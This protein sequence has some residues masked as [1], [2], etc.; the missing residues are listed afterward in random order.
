MQTEF[1][2]DSLLISTHRLKRRWVELCTDLLPVENK[3]TI[4]RYSRL[5]SEA[6]PAQGWKIHVSSTVLTA[7]EILSA[8]GPYLRSQGILFKAPTSL[9]VL[10]RLNSGIFYGY[11]QIGKFIT[12]YPESERQFKSLVPALRQLTANWHSGPT[13]PFDIR[14]QKSCIYY[15]YGAFKTRMTVTLEGHSVTS[16]VKPDGS[17]IEDSRHISSEHLG[18]VKDPISKG[19]KVSSKLHDGL[20]NDRYLVFR[21]LAQ[22]GKGG[23]YE[24]LDLKTDP[25]RL[26]ILKEGRSNGETSWD[27]RDGTWRIMNET[28][29]LNLLGDAEARVPSVY[30]SF[31]LDKNEYLVMEK[32]DGI[33]LRTLIIEG[34]SRFSIRERIQIGLQMC[35]I[36][37]SIHNVGWVW[38][39]CKPSNFLIDREGVVWA[40]DFEGA[41]PIAS[42]DRLQWSTPQYSPPEA[43]VQKSTAGQMVSFTHDLYSLGVCLEQLFEVEQ[44]GSKRNSRETGRTNPYLR[45]EILNP[46]S[47]LLDHDPSKRPDADYISGILKKALSFN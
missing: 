21:A 40:V 47:R 41:C 46:V 7:W 2:I 10:A 13:V 23:V 19:S 25:P 26:C 11:T 24:G 38:R 9:D 3:D 18:W 6:D 29:V 44:T 31:C 32:I 43:L 34:L 35:S 15:R 16:I 17:E 8:I 39:D 12:I 20:F 37:T 27:R 5:P 28:T 33:D 22:R 45:P 1:S 42:S 30:E 4:W 36:L 14:F